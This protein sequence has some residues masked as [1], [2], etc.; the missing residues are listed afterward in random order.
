MAITCPHGLPASECLICPRLPDAPKPARTPDRRRGS[1]SLHV[2]GVIAAIAL[3]SVVVWL[4]YGVV[5]GIL[6][7]F[8]LVLVG[9]TA[10]WAGYRL[11][12]YR[13]V[14]DGRRHG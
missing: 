13:G 12:H 10:G 4:V 14:R 6:H 1:L 11:G 2:A 3:L 8:E 9:G 5:F 7:V